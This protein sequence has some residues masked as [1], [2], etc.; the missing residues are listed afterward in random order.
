MSYNDTISVRAGADLTGSQYLAMEID[1]TVAG[2]ALAAVG[3]LGNKPASGEDATI[4]YQGR[5]KFVAGGTVAA[6]GPLAVNSTGFFTAATST[7]QVV[8]T[9]EIAASSGSITHGIFN[10]AALGYYA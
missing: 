10:F 6:G 7:D 2:S 5:S 3:I 8:G 4:V 9:C 1:G